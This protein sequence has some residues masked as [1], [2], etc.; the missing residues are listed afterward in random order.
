[1]PVSSL[2]QDIKLKFHKHKKSVGTVL[3]SVPRSEALVLPNPV[4]QTTL[5]PTPI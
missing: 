4:E 5:E 2:R 1:M 3:S